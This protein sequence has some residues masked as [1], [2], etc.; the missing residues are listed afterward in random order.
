MLALK[1]DAQF[2]VI[3]AAL[4]GYG[5]WR[6]MQKVKRKADVVGQEPTREQLQM[7][8]SLEGESEIINSNLEK[9]CLQLQRLRFKVISPAK[10]LIMVLI[11]NR[12]LLSSN[13]LLL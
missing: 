2:S 3:E 4:I 6:A 8:E 13:V 1:I 12:I 7:D 11:S 5:R 10:I 9:W